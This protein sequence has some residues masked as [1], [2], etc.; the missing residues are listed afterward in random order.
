V[1]TAIAIMAFG[2]IVET[3]DLF[4]EVAAPSLGGRVRSPAGATFGNVA[5]LAFVVLGTGMVIIAAVRFLALAKRID[6][7]ELELGMGARLDVTLAALLALLGSALF[8]YLGQAV[9]A[10][11]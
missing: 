5:G 6:R 4:L 7:A 2:F 8:L 9:V 1:R 3:F 11:L 10:R